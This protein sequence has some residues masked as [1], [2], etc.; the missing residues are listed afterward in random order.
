VARDELGTDLIPAPC[1]VGGPSDGAALPAADTACGRPTGTGTGT[2][3]RRLGATLGAAL[4]LPFPAG[5]AD[6][7]DS[8]RPRPDDTC[9]RTT[10]LRQAEA[11]R[12]TG[13]RG[14]RS[15]RGLP[16]RADPTSARALTP[17][18]GRPSGRVLTT[19][20][21]PRVPGTRPASAGAGRCSAWPGL[22]AEG[23]RA[24]PPRPDGSP[25]TQPLASPP[26][27]RP[28]PA[29]GIERYPRPTEAGS[30]DPRTRVGHRASALWVDTPHGGPARRTTAAKPSR[31][32]RLADRTRQRRPCVPG[33][34]F[35]GAPPARQRTTARQVD[36][37]RPSGG[38]AA[39]EVTGTPRFR[40]E[41]TARQTERVSER[42]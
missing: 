40:R 36:S 13:T 17:S 25:R 34:P 8:V 9:A 33:R 2:A 3:E 24:A 31:T 20:S 1:A 10:P 29:V 22:H 5:L 39:G 4:G 32:A 12:R 18:A 28:G 27:G 38:R 19:P 16:G 6:A 35:G 30:W 37:C 41:L 14:R 26:D 42:R 21:R 15:G 11:G 23:R 7:P